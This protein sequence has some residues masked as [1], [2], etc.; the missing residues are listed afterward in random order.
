MSED[1]KADCLRLL[2][3][4]KLDDSTYEAIEEALDKIEAPMTADGKW[5]TL[6]ER[7]LAI[8]SQVR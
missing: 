1:L 6:V 2:P 4:G 8:R 7:I 5:L 3:R